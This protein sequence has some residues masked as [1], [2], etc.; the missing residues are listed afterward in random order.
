MRIIA[1][2]LLL[3]GTSLWGYSEYQADPNERPVFEM[4][5]GTDGK[6]APGFSE[7][8]PASKKSGTF[9]MLEATPL[10]TYPINPNSD[11]YYLGLGMDAALG[12]GFKVP[13]TPLR[14]YTFIGL[15]FG[16]FKMSRFD[17]DRGTLNLNAFYF[18]YSLGV[19][20]YFAFRRHRI[21]INTEMGKT[22]LSYDFSETG[23]DQELSGKSDH[24]SFKLGIGYQFRYSY[25]WSFGGK[26]DYHIPVGNDEFVNTTYTNHSYQEALRWFTLGLSAV[27]H[28]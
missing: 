13:G 19:R 24:L 20:A 26:I 23:L 17:Q 7:D 5:E 25:H 12:A 11:Q 16:N 22:A 2:C 3:L 8:Q 14:L 21:F 18:N 4:P 1:L 15:G 9:F 27:L 6:Y 10:A 28:F